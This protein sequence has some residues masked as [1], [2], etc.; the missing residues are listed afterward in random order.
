MRQ[1]I[2]TKKLRLF[3]LILMICVLPACGGGGSTGGASDSVGG[4]SVSAGGSNVSVGGSGVSVGGSNVSVGG[5]SAGSGASV[6]L[7]WNAT[8]SDDYQ[9]VSYVAGGSG[10]SIVAYNVYYGTT[11]GQY[12]DVVKVSSGVCEQ[13]ACAATVSGLDKGATYYF[14]VTA[15]DSNGNES[16]YSSPW[17]EVAQ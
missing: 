7:T 12:P 1:H 11:Q 6:S 15:V 10:P 9:Q 14:A 16:N 4:A 2:L 17:T 3:V 5:A 8:T 13:T